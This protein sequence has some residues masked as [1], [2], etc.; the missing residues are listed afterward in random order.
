MDIP[1]G[2]ADQLGNPDMPLFITEGVKKAD[3]GALRR[4]VHRRPIRCVELA[5]HQQRRRQNGIP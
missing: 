5:A 2:V 3:C 4:P 1:P